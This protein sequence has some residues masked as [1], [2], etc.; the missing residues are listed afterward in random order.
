MNVF[1]KIYQPHA[2]NWNE[3][4]EAELWFLHINCNCRGHRQSSEALSADNLHGCKST[5]K[6]HPQKL[7]KYRGVPV[8]SSIEA[9]ARALRKTRWWG[10]H[11]E[12]QTGKTERGWDGRVG[13]CTDLTCL[14]YRPVEP[15]NS[16]VP[17]VPIVAQISDNDLCLAMIVGD[18]YWQARWPVSVRCQ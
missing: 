13:V 2:A 11:R 7:R 5:G 18:R 15:V 17:E 4:T 12:R 3:N 6:K 10:R 1:P 9:T 8:N 16:A 14:G